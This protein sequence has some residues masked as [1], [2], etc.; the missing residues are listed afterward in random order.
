MMTTVQDGGRVGFQQYGMPV[1]GP[2][3]GESYAIG[4]A[5]VGNTTPVGALECTV[6][7][8]TLKVKGT[9]IVAFTGADMRPT[10]NNVEVPRYIP[11]VCHDGDV[12]SGSF[13]QCG[14]RMYISF[15]G[16]IDVPE[17]NGSVATHTKANIGGFEGH[18]LVAGDEVRLKDCTRDTII[19]DYTSESNHLF[20][21]VLFNRGGRECHEPLRVVLGS[22]AK[23]FTETGIRNFSSELYTLTIQCDRMGFRLD[24]APVEHIDG[25]DIISDGAVF[26]SIQVP[27]DGNPIILMADRQTTGAIQKS[28]PLLLLICLD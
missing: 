24:G 17:I 20:N 26:G 23:Y 28:A 8:P 21:T 19:C 16:G 18:P 15:A 5:L 7:S 13:S 9:C 2:M 27:S 22:Q 10:I 3:D 12:I 11:F 4:Q 14:V 25:A 6:L 1:A